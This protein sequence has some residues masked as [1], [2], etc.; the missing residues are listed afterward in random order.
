M[1]RSYKRDAKGR[2]A[3][4]S[5]LPSRGPGSLDWA[6]SSISIR[7]GEKSLKKARI[8]RIYQPKDLSGVSPHIPVVRRGRLAPQAS[9]DAKKLREQY[10]SYLKGHKLRGK[11][12][13]YR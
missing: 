7:R 4:G 10:I 13:G 6:K 5:G 9:A 11:G 2:F 3:S 1:A 12:H 8:I